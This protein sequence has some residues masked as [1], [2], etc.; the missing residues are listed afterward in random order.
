MGLKLIP[1][2]LLAVLLVSGCLRTEEDSFYCGEEGHYNGWSCC[3]GGDCWF[4]DKLLEKHCEDELPS[5]EGNILCEKI[6]W[7][8]KVAEVSGIKRSCY[9]QKWDEFNCPEKRASDCDVVKITKDSRGY[10]NIKMQSG[11]GAMVYEEQYINETIDTLR[12][13]CL[14]E[15]GASFQL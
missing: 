1:L 8:L 2:V 5:S 11:V 10:Y 3:D 13:K 9:F 6:N 14:E 15:W 7:G 12:A 4:S